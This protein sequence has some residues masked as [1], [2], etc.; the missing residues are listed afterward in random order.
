MRL[1]CKRVQNAAHALMRVQLAAVLLVPHLQGLSRGLEISGSAAAQARRLPARRRVVT[2][3]SPVGGAAL[4]LAAVGALLPSTGHS[5]C[6]MQMLSACKRRFRRGAGRREHASW[7]RSQAPPSHQLT[8]AVLALLL[9][10][11]CIVGRRVGERGRRPGCQQLTSAHQRGALGQHPR[12]A[13]PPLTFMVPLAEQQG[14]AVPSSRVR[15]RCGLLTRHSRD[16]LS[17]RAGKGGAAPCQAFGRGAR[18]AMQWRRG[19]L[20]LV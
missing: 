10:L 20:G 5:P 11:P 4:H 16:E 14:H 8:Q 9:V 12:P 2:I 6:H 13:P 17:E 3:R 19:P 15:A 7:R 18:G 1:P